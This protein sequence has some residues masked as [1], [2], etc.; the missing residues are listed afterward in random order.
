MHDPLREPTEA[1]ARARALLDDV[2]GRA[3]ETTERA[4]LAAELAAL[5][6]EDAE[7]RERP[8]ER[9]RRLL[10][11]RLLE[12]EARLKRGAQPGDA[13]RDGLLQ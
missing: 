12:V 5:L 2:R 6:H 1:V 3:L 4:D 9:G 11:G 10:L 7:R 13:F 8:S